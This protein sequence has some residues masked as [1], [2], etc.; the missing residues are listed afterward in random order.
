M[1]P[2]ANPFGRRYWEDRYAAPGLAWSGQPNPVMV[3][4]VGLLKPGR[5]LDVGS[6]E[7]GD[8]LW[9]ARHGWHVTGI[10]IAATALEKARA[11][12]EADD[13][14]AA[15]RI[16]WQQHDLTA[17]SPKRQGFD[18][19]SSQFMHLPEPARTTLFRSLATAVAPGGT[20]L[21][22]GHDA[23]VDDLSQR[24]KHLSGL[25]Y[26][27]DDILAAIDGEDLRIEVAE[28]R[29]RQARN[30]GAGSATVHDV[31]VRASRPHSARAV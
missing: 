19:V 12:A 26:S 17:W 23:D 27:V 4:E 11:H 22:V 2:E 21:V 1:A 25:T 7:G 3:T 16:D 8:A 13:P 10:D 9:L 6:G 31:V 20:L 24:R 28:S 30:R 5:A 14:K 15:A 29:S 18:L